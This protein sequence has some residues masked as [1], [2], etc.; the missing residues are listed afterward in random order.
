MCEALAIIALSLG[1]T[2]LCS[3]PE[4]YKIINNLIKSNAI[5][6]A[7][8][9]PSAVP[10]TIHYIHARIYAR[11]QRR[12]AAKHKTHKYAWRSLTRIARSLRLIFASRARS[13]QVF[14][15][16]VNFSS[17]P[18]IC[19]ANRYIYRVD[20]RGQV[21]VTEP[22]KKYIYILIDDRVPRAHSI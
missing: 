7:V 8:R 15:I 21:C 12:C 13:S 20:M 22:Q 16:Y 6:R 17:R 5:A 9:L 19:H 1:A 18:Q 3:A 10:R 14:H 11:Y 2:R 4:I